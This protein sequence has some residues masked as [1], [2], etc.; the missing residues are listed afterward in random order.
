LPDRVR[1]DAELRA[2][3]TGMHQTD[4]RC[5]RIDD[6]N[7]AAVRDVNAQHDPALIGDDAV[8]AGEFAARRA[9]ATAINHCDFVSVNLFCGEQW[10][11]ADANCVANFAMCGF[12]S[13]QHFCFSMRNFDA[14][15]SLRESMATDS[16]RAQRR[17]LL[18]GTIHGSSKFQ[19]P[20]S[21][22]NCHSDPAVA[23]EESRI[24]SA[25]REES[26]QRCFQ[27]SQKATAWQ[28]LGST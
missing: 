4:G 14:G 10:P 17:K 21:S 3:A 18:E 5:F 7:S 26:N 15:N 2:F 20:T 13:P 23:G 16:N 27:P 25:E 22:R 12:E 1:H 6:V 24:I 28:A 19:A 11:V 8:A 9:A